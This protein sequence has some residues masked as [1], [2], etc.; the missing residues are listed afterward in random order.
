[1]PY[2]LTLTRWYDSQK[3]LSPTINKKIQ[4]FLVLLDHYVNFSNR[5]GHIV[6]DHICLK[7]L[8]G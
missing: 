1:M 4:L 6:S 2:E 8:R 3:N 5:P 7:M